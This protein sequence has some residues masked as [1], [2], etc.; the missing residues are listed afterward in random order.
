MPRDSV[1]VYFFCKIVSYLTAPKLLNLSN[2]REARRGT[3]TEAAP[4]E[5]RWRE[6]APLHPSLDLNRAGWFVFLFSCIIFIFFKKML[7]SPARAV[8]DVYVVRPRSVYAVPL[9]PPDPGLPKPSARADVT[10]VAVH[11]RKQISNK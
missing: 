5:E 1:G 6:L 11:W 7:H 9:V 2:A 10:P 3:T 8:L 4:A